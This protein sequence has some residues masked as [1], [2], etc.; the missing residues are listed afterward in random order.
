MAVQHLTSADFDSAISTGGCAGGFWATWCGPAALQTPITRRVRDGAL[1]GQGLQGGR[2]RGARAGL[3][4]RAI[5][6]IPTLIYFEDGKQIGKAVGVQMKEQ[7][8]RRAWRIR[9][10]KAAKAVD[11]ARGLGYNRLERG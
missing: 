1:R 3:A 5:M 9:P 8:A 6:S 7:I 11:F 4:L 2:G 10:Q